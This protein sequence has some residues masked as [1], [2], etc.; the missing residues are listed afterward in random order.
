[1]GR[2]I[3]FYW[4]HV[5]KSLRHVVIYDLHSQEEE[6]N[7]CCS[8][9][10]SLCPIQFRAWVQEMDPPTWEVGLPS[11]NCQ[12]AKSL[13]YLAMGKPKIILTFVSRTLLLGEIYPHPQHS[14]N[15]AVEIE[16]K[17]MM[18]KGLEMNMIALDLPQR[19]MCPISMPVVTV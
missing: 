9:A 2:Y 4:N 16:Q 6:R 19:P 14:Q 10:A 3:T 18:E 12:I 8:F 7:E 11:S 5:S 15:A 13:T 1:M 17:L